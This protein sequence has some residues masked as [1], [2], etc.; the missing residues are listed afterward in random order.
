MRVT[1]LP[2]FHS[3]S[4]ITSEAKNQWTFSQCCKMNYI[5]KVWTTYK[6]FI[7]FKKIFL[8]RSFFLSFSNEE[9]KRKRQQVHR[10]FGWLMLTT[11]IVPK[12]PLPNYRAPPF[13]QSSCSMKVIYCFAAVEQTDAQLE[14]ELRRADVIC[15]VY[16]VDDEDTLDSVTDHWLPFIRSVFIK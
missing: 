5:C 8:K 12:T 14:Y 15:V 3:T 6:I 7:K 2:Q 9:W 10:T 16:A 4:L 13:Y 1:D 11:L